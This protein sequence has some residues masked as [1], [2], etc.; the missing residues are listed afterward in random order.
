MSILTVVIPAK[1]EDQTLRNLLLRLSN[2]TMTDFSIIV[3]DNSSTGIVKDICEESKILCIAGGLPGVG[4]NCGARVARSR[5]I[6]FLDADVSIAP[7]FI[8]KALDVFETKK[9]DGMSFGFV[10]NNS[11][12]LLRILH[13]LLKYFFFYMSKLGFAHGIGGAILV[14]RDV[15]VSM[16]GFD[17][18]VYIAEDCEYVKRLSKNFLYCFVVEPT[19]TLDV[20]R[21]D[22]E[23]AWHVA[24]KLLVV[25]L[26]RI[27]LGEIRHKRIS[28]F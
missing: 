9:A 12:H 26:H 23:G 25:E 8:A 3:A 22:R 27:F 17:E 19:V 14:K 4:R 2:Q 16:G 21:L 7:D 10:P 5:Y 15:H 18:T 28:Y 1:D 13:G 24:W 6:L 20:R 11:H